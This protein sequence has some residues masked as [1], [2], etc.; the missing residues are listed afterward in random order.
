[1]GLF[2]FIYANFSQNTEDRGND[3]FFTILDDIYITSHISPS[4]SILITLVVRVKMF[5]ISKITC[6]KYT[7]ISGAHQVPSI[8][9]CMSAKSI[10]LHRPYKPYVSLTLWA[11]L[12]W[13]Q[14]CPRNTP[15]ASIL[16][17]VPCRSVKCLIFR[18]FDRP[19]MR[20]HVTCL[21][22]SVKVADFLTANFCLYRFNAI[23]IYLTT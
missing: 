18:A 6:R 22:S 3:C 20:V 4:L 12:T 21:A 2:L 13:C 9:P 11:T 17:H 16:F 19:P 14:V 7:V 1:M 5:Q 10:S 8:C 23:H 15:I